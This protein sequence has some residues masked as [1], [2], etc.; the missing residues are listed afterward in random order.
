MN[1]I[2][3]VIL[4]C[5]EIVKRDLTKEEILLIGIAYNSGFGDG[6]KRGNEK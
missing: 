1:K 6:M 2:D 4:K 5:A 3:A